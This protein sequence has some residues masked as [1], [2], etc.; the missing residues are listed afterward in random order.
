ML[1]W[2]SVAATGADAKLAE[3]A[4]FGGDRGE[5]ILFGDNRFIGNSGRVNRVETTICGG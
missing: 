5:S 2:T 3:A 4:V 1:E